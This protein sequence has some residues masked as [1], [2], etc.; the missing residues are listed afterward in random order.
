MIIRR[1]SGAD[2]FDYK[3]A[4]GPTQDSMKKSAA[5]MPAE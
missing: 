5:R 2:E 3:T 4:K 1:V